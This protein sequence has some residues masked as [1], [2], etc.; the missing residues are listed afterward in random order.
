MDHF[1]NLRERAR[2][3]QEKYQKAVVLAGTRSALDVYCLLPGQQQRVHAHPETEKYY[4]VW[5]GT[6]TVTVGPETRV[7]GPGEAAFA[8]P[9]VPHGVANSG[10]E[11]ALVVVFQTP[12]PA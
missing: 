5:Q 11:P 10:Q 3:N 12:R 9:G 7:L 4:L 6:V 8:P 2:F 1:G